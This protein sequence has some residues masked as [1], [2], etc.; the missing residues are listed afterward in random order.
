[1][2]QGTNVNQNEAIKS[3]EIKVARIIQSEEGNPYKIIERWNP[4]TKDA[5]TIFNW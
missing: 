1:M 5:I 3:I 2:L 4:T